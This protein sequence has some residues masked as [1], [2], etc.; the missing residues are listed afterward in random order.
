M[1]HRSNFN[2]LSTMSQQE[3]DKL[4]VQLQQMGAIED[5]PT[6]TSTAKS[7]QTMPSPTLT[8]PSKG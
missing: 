2:K 4:M 7:P 3:I 5:K 1:S 6:S 8:H